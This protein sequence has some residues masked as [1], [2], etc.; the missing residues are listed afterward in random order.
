[1]RVVDPHVHLWD[2]KDVAIPWLE[3]PGEAFSG[4]NHELPRV[5]TLDTLNSVSGD[6]DV[7]KCV[8]VEAVAADPMA[9]AHWIQSIAE[10]TDYPLGIVAFAD[11][12][13]SDFTHQ[14]ERLLAF[15]RLRGIR[16]IL[17]V[18]A[19]PVYDYVGRHYMRE[20][21]WQ[22]NLDVL[23]AHRLS[24]D[25]QVY[26]NQMLEAAQVAE[27]HP[28]VTF[29]L[30]HA[31]MFVDRDTVAGWRTWRNGLA[32][33]AS[34][35]NVAAKISGLAM[36]DHDWTLESFRP[37]V[38]ETIAAFGTERCMFASNFPIDG[39]H[40]GYAK[41]WHAYAEIVSGARND[42]WCALSIGNA[43]RIYR[44]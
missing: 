26:P 3:N 44:L 37:Y 20:P 14:L 15:G 7:V 43:E 38:L 41:L 27:R 12:S 30:D 24:F 34:C 18:H 39:L 32:S 13:R 6:V 33:L 11:L 8:H 10:R 17:N 23:G 22:R 19:N 31:G 42:E 29:V 25:L 21:V 35:H 36:F 28:E 4:D 5:F 2:P 40:A 9:E 16:Q 1:M